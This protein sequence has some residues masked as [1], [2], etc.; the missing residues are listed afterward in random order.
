[1][2][3]ILI[4]EETIQ[5]R[6]TELADELYE[7]YG[8]EKVVFICTLKGAVFFTCD[9]LKKYKGRAFVDFLR[10]SSYDGD[11]STGKVSLNLSVSE[12]SIKGQN[13]IIMEDIVDTGRSID[14]LYDY[15]G[16][17]SPKT[18]T[19]C[20]LLYKE[21]KSTVKNKPDYVG[22]KIDDLFVIG[23]GLDYN[24]EYRNLPY[25]KVLKNSR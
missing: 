21:E 7:T 24:Q 1:M 18:L 8:D 13:V 9:L 22:F 2:D 25:I 15:I 5:K 11:H 14:F 6:I 4:D 16:K 10:V 19:T 23:Y 3:E 20:T 17:M 12:E